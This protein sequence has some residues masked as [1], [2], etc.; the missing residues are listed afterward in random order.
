[1]DS[2]EER[3]KRLNFCRGRTTS[4]GRSPLCSKCR[5][6]Q[7]KERFPLR[8]SFHHLRNRARERG[9]TFEISFAQYKEFARSTGYADLKGKHS[10]SLSIHRIDNSIG[11][12]ADNISCVTMSENSRLQYA[13]I[14]DWLRR[15]HKDD[16][17]RAGA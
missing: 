4:G 8:Y 16:C 1:M 2:A 9:H 10:S 12:R 5:A 13:P 15:R 3:N 6:R 7:W 11:Y 14:P 17:R